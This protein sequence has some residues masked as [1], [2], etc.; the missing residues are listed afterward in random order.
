MKVTLY[1]LRNF[2]ALDFMDA[3]EGYTLSGGTFGL[4]NAPIVKD[5]KRTQVEFNTLAQ[6][7][8]SNSSCPTISRRRA[9]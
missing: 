8:R 5:A 3:V 2:N 6:K 1:G 9:V 4:M 7:K